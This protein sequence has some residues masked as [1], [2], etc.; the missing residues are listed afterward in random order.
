MRYPVFEVPASWGG[1]DA[2]TT[3]NRLWSRRRPAHYPG[4]GPLHT[5]HDAERPP[6][7]WRRSAMA[8]RRSLL[9]CL[10]ARLL[11]GDKREV[12]THGCVTV[13][14]TICQWPDGIAYPTRAYYQRLWWCLGSG[15]D[16]W[17]KL[18]WPHRSDRTTVERMHTLPCLKRF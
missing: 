9:G 2:E 16:R 12:K 17:R 6:G 4:F 5:L 1:S 11:A 8:G 13:F 18:T 14:S 15:S 3:Q 10:I 7:R